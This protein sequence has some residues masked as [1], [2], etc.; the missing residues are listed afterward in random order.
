VNIERS[1][2]KCKDRQGRLEEVEKYATTGSYSSPKS[3]LD[4]VPGG[5]PFRAVVL[6]LSHLGD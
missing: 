4:T 2:K 6:D 1:I 3:A 5:N